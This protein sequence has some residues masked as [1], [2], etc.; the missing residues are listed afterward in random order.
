MTRS[1]KEKTVHVSE[2]KRG[3]EEEG[4]EELKESDINYITREKEIY[5]CSIYHT[6]DLKSRDKINAHYILASFSLHGR[7]CDESSACLLS[8]YI[9]F[10][11]DIS[12]LSSRSVYETF[13]PGRAGQ[14][15]AELPLQ[16]CCLHHCGAA[17]CQKPGA[18]E[19]AVIPVVCAVGRRAE[20]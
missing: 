6:A 13:F 1:T 10:P 19:E 20:C 5:T 12:P 14:E 2:G 4:R 16:H 8:L 18:G 15:D 9:T 3:G 11:G 7:E 17:V